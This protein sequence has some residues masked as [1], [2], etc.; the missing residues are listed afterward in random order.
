M[1]GA[2]LYGSHV[3]GDTKFGV[4]ATE[5]A[6]NLNRAQ[7]GVLFRNIAVFSSLPAKSRIPELDINIDLVLHNAQPRMGFGV[8]G[9]FDEFGTAL[10]VRLSFGNYAVII[11]GSVA[12][13]GP[14]QLGFKAISLFRITSPDDNAIKWSNIGSLD[15]TKTQDNV[16]G[17]KPLEWKGFVYKIKMLGL[18]NQAL[19]YGVNGI[20]RISPSG[21]F[22][23]EKK[24]FPTGI[25][26][27][28]AMIETLKKHFFISTFGELWSVDESL[29]FINHG[30]KEFLN[31]L[32]A[33]VMTYD[34]QNELIYICDGTTGYVYSILDDSLTNGYPAISGIGFQDSVNF[35]ISSS[36]L[37]QPVF[38]ITSDI[39]N[40][41][42]RKNKTVEKIEIE[43]NYT[44][45]LAVSIDYRTLQNQAFTSIPWF[46]FYGKGESTIPCYG[47]DFK[48][49]IKAFENGITFNIKEFKIY[50][51]IH[52]FMYR[53]YLSGR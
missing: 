22:Y 9:S 47:V 28:E 30:Y 44:G 7:T 21:V 23:G 52:D 40:F 24:V 10:Q 17:K 34:N 36:S 46:I 1:Y 41:G 33:V 4:Y 53:D 48:F 2:I 45:Q 16:A 29:N 20:S 39:I 13:N 19:V 42:T 12:A 5:I 25:K 35:I 6:V 27:K 49:K 31:P 26:S 51:T 50:G 8:Y 43:T 37:T 11:P 14:V 38:S 32:S 15:F 18:N 3:F